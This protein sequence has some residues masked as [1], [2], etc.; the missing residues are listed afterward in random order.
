MNRCPQKR[1]QNKGEV[2]NSPNR[3]RPFFKS[4]FKQKGLCTHLMKVGRET[5]LKGF[6]NLFGYIAIRLHKSEVGVS[7]TSPMFSLIMNYNMRSLNQ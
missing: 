2:F 6:D 7:V 3:K 4:N 5:F 1:V